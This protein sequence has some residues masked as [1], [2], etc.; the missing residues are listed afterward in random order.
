MKNPMTL[1]V[2]APASLLA[3]TAMAQDKAPAAAPTQ[4]Q[5]ARSR[6]SPSSAGAAVTKPSTVLAT[7]ISRSA[8]LRMK[9]A[10]R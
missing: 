2:L 10:S 3:T 5:R 1:T 8:S 4:R 9:N 6:P 7:M